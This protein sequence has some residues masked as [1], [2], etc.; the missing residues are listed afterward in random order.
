[1]GFGACLRGS[2]ARFAVAI[3]MLFALLSSSSLAQEPNL[4]QSLGGEVASS[5]SQEQERRAA[6]LAADKTHG[7]AQY[8]S[9]NVAALRASTMR[10][11]LSG[12]SA[13]RL[14]L[15]H[16]LERGPGDFTWIGS[17]AADGG[18]TVLVFRNDEVTG[19]IYDGFEQYSL[20]PIGGGLHALTK[21][22]RGAFPPDHPP[23]PLPR[24][25][26]DSNQVRGDASGSGPIEIDFLGVYTTNAA[27]SDP[28][29]VSNIQLAVDMANAAY[30]VSNANVQMRLVGTLMVN[31]S[32][33][34]KTYSA[35]LNDITNGTGAMSAAHA[36][37]DAV[38]ADL[39]GLFVN[40][41]EYCGLAWLDSTANYAFSVTTRICISNHTFAHEIGHNFGAIHDVAN[42]VGWST[43]PY[44]YGYIH[45]QNL[46]RTIQS[47]GSPCSNCPRIGNFSNPHVN[48]NG[49]P[50]GT[51][52]THDVARVHRERAATIAAFRPSGGGGGEVK[53]AITSPTP[54]STLSSATVTFNWNAGSGAQAYRITA[55][56]TV[57]GTQYH[58]SGSLGTAVRSRSIASLPTNGSTVRVR[59]YT[60]FASGWQHTDYTYTAVTSGGTKAV[61]TQPV[62][63]VTLSGS[64]VTFNWSAGTNATGYYLDVG[65]FQGG[66]NIH[67][68]GTLSAGTLS[69]TVTDL[70]TDGSTLYVRLYTGLPGTSNIFTHYNDYTYTAGS[71]AVKAV[72][73]SPTPGSTLT[74]TS[75]TF[76][77]TAGTGVSSYWL[78][79][80]SNGAGSANI[81]SGGGAQTSR[82][83]GSLP[84]T[85]TL[86]V[87]LMSY[88]A[89][90]WQFNDYTY[91]MNA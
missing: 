85:G 34:G 44:A 12:D 69:R 61:M 53:A 87:R 70:P 88:I 9:V 30:L 59:L 19:V 58:D 21:T 8:V 82:T 41:L 33:A 36:E 77:W 35:M 74:S 78:Q 32:E 67:D 7:P 48:H 16:K 5:L 6:A 68:S 2:A 23:G 46:W 29:I 55:G 86:N 22:D 73:T 24:A 40:S 39:V 26:R 15:Q 51:V 42:S 13:I 45:P 76:N 14:R 57:G 66:W 4:L 81:F 54:G 27:S 83:V 75:V 47:Y 49:H 80:G 65:S 56:S 28:N 17:T 37:R 84:A 60:Q 10:V 11:A 89:G 62:P 71:A 25:P 38:G 3:L 31:Y 50:T 20:T 64:T 63:G 18:Q 90:G 79:V 1:M 52:T 91:T 43:Y 72:M